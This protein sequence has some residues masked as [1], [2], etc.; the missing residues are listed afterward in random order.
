MSL[1]VDNLRF[2][3]PDVP[4]LRD[5]SFRV[6]TGDFL[7]LLGPNGSGKS[8]LLRLLDRILIP[9]SGSITLKD[10]PLNSYTRREL[11]R[12]V[13]YVPQDTTWVFPYTVFEVVLMGRSPYIGSSGFE[14]ADDLDCAR[15]VMDL[16]DIG[17]LADKPIT[18]ISGGERQRAL[19]ARALC[20]QPEILLL[21]EP[22]AH[23]DINHQVEMFQILREQNEKNNL[24]IISVS[25]DLNLAAA[26]SKHVLLLSESS[27]N[28]STIFA[29]G[30]PREVLTE[31][32]ISAVYRTPVLVDQLPDSPTVRISLMPQLSRAGKP[33]G[34]R[35]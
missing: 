18:A 26:F 4:V 27:G 11:A 3:Y 15:A 7:S 10:R 21:D 5:V 34:G 33:A 32:N 24:T 29:D 22:N 31:S 19:I 6:D 17:R 9:E 2:H 14:N 1:S 25:H 28:G 13:A 16:T 23:L 8:T 35:H 30:T 12:L 20:Q